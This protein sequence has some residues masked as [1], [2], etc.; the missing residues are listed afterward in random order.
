MVVRTQEKHADRRGLIGLHIGTLNVQTHFPR[1]MDAVELE[2]DHL[3]I[4]CPLEPS[5]WSDSPV[6]HDHRL[7][8]WLEAKRTGG[9]LVGKAAP[10]TLLPLENGRAFRLQLMSKE[11][12]ECAVESQ[13]PKT[14][15]AVVL[16]QPARPKVLLDRRQRDAEHG[17]ERRRPARHKLLNLGE[18]ERTSIAANH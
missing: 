11:E 2:L 18:D 1:G 12:A 15:A 10:V 9:K 4:V 6:I 17:P 3:R 5:F 16:G 14:A 8:L 7:S 13:E